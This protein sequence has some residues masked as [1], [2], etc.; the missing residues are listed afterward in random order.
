MRVFL[1]ILGILYWTCSSFAQSYLASSGTC[2]PAVA[3]LPLAE[4]VMAADLNP[5]RKL[6]DDL[7]PLVDVPITQATSGSDVF[8]WLPADFESGEIGPFATAEALGC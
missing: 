4:D 1:I 7:T 2:G 3:H 6:A 5:H 8:L